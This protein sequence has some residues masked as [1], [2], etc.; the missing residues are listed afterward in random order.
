MSAQSLSI[1]RINF[2]EREPFV[3]TYKKMIIMG[4]A[5][6]GVVL[7]FYGVQLTRLLWIE[8]NVTRLTEEVTQLKASRE[9]ALLEAGSETGG[10]VSARAALLKILTHATSWSAVVRELTTETPHSLWLTSLKSYEKAESLSRRGLL[11][12][13]QAEEAESVTFFLKAL[14]G[15]PYFTNVVLTSSK[16]ESGPSGL[17]YQFSIDL[18]VT[19]SKRGGGL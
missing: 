12:N 6:F 17:L 15:S 9:R 2:I 7:F 10:L 3:L 16:Q 13:G 18:I 8:K 14:S 19:P 1:Q 4:G 5:L 11:L